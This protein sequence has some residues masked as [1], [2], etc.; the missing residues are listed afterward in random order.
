LLSSQLNLKVNSDGTISADIKDA[1]ASVEDGKVTSDIT[2]NFGGQNI[3]NK[4]TVRMRDEHIDNM[5]MLVPR[6]MIP[7]ALLF[8]MDPKMISEVVEVPMTGNLRKPQLDFAGAVKKSFTPLKGVDNPINL[9]QGR[10]ASSV[11]LPF[12]L[13]HA[14]WATM[15]CFDKPL[16]QDGVCRGTPRCKPLLSSNWAKLSIPRAEG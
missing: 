2:L 10:R 3:G 7:K 5:L 11:P 1:K 14:L 4:G 9:G 15:L 16:K 12:T 13:T 8:G 6:D